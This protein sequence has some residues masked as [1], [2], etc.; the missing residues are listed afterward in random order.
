MTLESLSA[1]TIATGDLAAAVRFYQT[2]GFHTHYVHGDFA[3][4][5]LNGVYLN[6]AYREGYRPVPNWGRIIFYVDDVDEFYAN[7]LAAGL[8]PDTAPR[9]AE[10]HERYF[11]ITDP[12]GHELSFAKPLPR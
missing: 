12:S 2:L 10:W 5:T 7:V 11:H 3:S 9:D 6:L 1:V 4:F 8:Q